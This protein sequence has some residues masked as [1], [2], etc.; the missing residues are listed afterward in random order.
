ML[1][2]AIAVARKGV[3]TLTL[4]GCLTWGLNYC[5]ADMLGEDTRSSQTNSIAIYEEN[6]ALLADPLQFELPDKSHKGNEQI[7]AELR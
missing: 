6:E 7:D 4:W 2:T 1:A 5:L 3:L